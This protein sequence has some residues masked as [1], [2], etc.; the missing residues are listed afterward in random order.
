MVDI[1][2]QGLVQS[3]HEL[4]HAAGPPPKFLTTV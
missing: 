4:G 2:I 3:E 1:T